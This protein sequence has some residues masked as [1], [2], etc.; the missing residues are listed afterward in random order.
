VITPPLQLVPT[1]PV[2]DDM[3]LDSTA[4]LA[5]TEA[6]T[7]NT[8]AGSLITSTL[9]DAS[10]NVSS[11]STGSLT[12]ATVPDSSNQSSSTSVDTA[13]RRQRDAPTASRR[14]RDTAARQ[15]A[16]K[17]NKN[18]STSGSEIDLTNSVS[19]SQR[20]SCSLCESKTC[21]ACN[22]SCSSHKCAKCLH[23][24]HPFCALPQAEGHG[25]NVLCIDCSKL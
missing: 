5:S 10:V 22:S 21:H 24:Y 14:Q 17:K 25:E 6:A 23:L 9:S 16:E 1:S 11:S 15:V 12:T 4:D 8:S 20:E 19:E 18:A 13:S 3:N 7:V 2:D